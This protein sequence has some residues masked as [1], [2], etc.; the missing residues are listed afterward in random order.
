MKLTG[1]IPHARMLT[2]HQKYDS[3]VMARNI[4]NSSALDIEIMEAV[5][6]VY[7][8]MMLHHLTIADKIRDEYTSLIFSTQQKVPPPN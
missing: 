8:S 5:G 2:K 7:H 4:A 3:F 1:A 6:K